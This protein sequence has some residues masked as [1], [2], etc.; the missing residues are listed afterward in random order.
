MNIELNTQEAQILLNAL[1]GSVRANGLG[2]AS[3]ALALANKIQRAA[4]EVEKAESPN[5]K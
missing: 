1:D 4:E 3:D 2:V 5:K